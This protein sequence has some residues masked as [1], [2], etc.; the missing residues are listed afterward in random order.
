MIVLDTNV[1]SET[2]RRRPTPSVLTWFESIPDEAL[3]VS[4]LTLGEIRR[5]VD[6]LAETEG[7]QPV[8]HALGHR[9]DPVR[10]P[11]QRAIETAADPG[12]R[13]VR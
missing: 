9:D 13:T 6:R 12:K 2:V 11:R 5:G 10:P 4:V 8:A 7:D 3:H 1:L